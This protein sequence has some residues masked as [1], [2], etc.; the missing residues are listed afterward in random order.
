M[1]SDYFE[2]KVQ[3]VAE[4][5]NVVLKTT[6]S[7]DGTCPHLPDVRFGPPSLVNPAPTRIALYASVQVPGVDSKKP[8]SPPGVLGFLPETGL[9]PVRL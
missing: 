6:T 1:P 7:G 3:K 8:K 5:I 9:E 4:S 2:K